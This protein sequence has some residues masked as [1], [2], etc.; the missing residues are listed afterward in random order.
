MAAQLSAQ[1]IRKQKTNKQ[2][3]PNQNL[4]L[5]GTEIFSECVKFPARYFQ[6]T[7]SFC[8]IQSLSGEANRLPLIIRESKVVLEFHRTYQPLSLVLA[9][10]HLSSL[11]RWVQRALHHQTIHQQPLVIAGLI[12]SGEGDFNDSLYY[13][14]LPPSLSSISGHPAGLGMNQPPTCDEIQDGTYISYNFSQ[15]K[16]K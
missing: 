9:S 1:Y 16:K 12:L 7:T 10:H 2:N 5:N 13:S 6:H 8:G 15:L 3:P 11:D 14:T 4:V